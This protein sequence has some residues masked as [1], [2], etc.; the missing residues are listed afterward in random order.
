VIVYDPLGTGTLGGD[1]GKGAEIYDDPLLFLQDMENPGKIY[2]AHVFIDEA[3]EIFS[4]EQKDN[5]WILKKGRHYGLSIW[6]ITQR[7]KMV[8]PTVRNQCADAY[9]FRLA[10][11]DVKEIAA[12]FGHSNIHALELAHGDYIVLHSGHPEFER[13]SIHKLPRGK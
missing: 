8:A 13:G 4:Q 3:D 6:V 7:P 1:W 5:F 2:N 10:I 11:Q 12:D 9:L